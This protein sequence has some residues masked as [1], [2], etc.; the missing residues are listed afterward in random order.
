MNELNDILILVPGIIS[1]K[2]YWSYI[3]RG[4]YDYDQN[5]RKLSLVIL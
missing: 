4:T 1:S 3:Q 2:D 5:A